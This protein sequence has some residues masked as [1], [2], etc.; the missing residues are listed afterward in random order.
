MLSWD[1]YIQEKAKPGSWNMA[2]DDYLFRSLEDFPRTVLSFYQWIRPTA[3][4]GYS[5]KVKDVADLDFCRDHGVDVVRRITGGKLVLHFNEVTYSLCSSDT[6]LFS[7]TL[8]ESYRRISEAL[9]R[10]LER[11]GL[12]PTLADAPPQEYSRGN[13]PCFSY[14][15][16]NEVEVQGKKIIGSVSF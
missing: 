11:M 2:V 10:G 9:V 15:A 12:R 5:Q 6:D 16:R 1:M 7:S 14:P 3:S 13:L 4:L 8:A